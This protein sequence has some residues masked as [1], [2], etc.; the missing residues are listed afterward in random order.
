MNSEYNSGKDIMKEKDGG[1]KQ[2]S[3]TLW[4]D[5]NK[6]SVP[7]WKRE[8]GA[9]PVWAWAGLSIAAAAAMIHVWI[10]SL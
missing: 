3:H 1:P 9:V 4:S 6:R 5:Y 8:I 2:V 10:F 7:L